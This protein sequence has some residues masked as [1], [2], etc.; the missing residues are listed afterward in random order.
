MHRSLKSIFA[1]LLPLMVLFILIAKTV[2]E[3]NQLHLIGDGEENFKLSYHLAKHGVISTGALD[4]AGNLLPSNAREPLPVVLGALWINMWPVLANADS[5][6]ELLLGKKIVLLKLQNVVYVAALLIGIFCLFFRLLPGNLSRLKKT[7]LATMVVTLC[8]ACMHTVFTN[9][10][11][12]EFH[13]ELLIIWFVWAWLSA[14]ESKG[15][16]C[17]FLAGLLLGLLVLTKAAFMYI[18]FASILFFLLFLVFSKYPIQIIFKQSIILIIA[19]LCVAPWFVRNYIQLGL[20]EHT[21]RGPVVLLVRAYKNAMTPEEFTGAFYA[22]APASLK[23]VMKSLT[24]FSATDRLT[25]G[26]L[27][28]LTRFPNGDLEKRAAGDEAGAISYYIKATTHDRNVH[29]DFQEKV[30]DQVQA[31]ILADQAIKKEA[32]KKITSDIPAHL[33][34]SLVFAW[35]GSWPCNTVDGRWKSSYPRHPVWQEFLPFL[36]LVSMWGILIFGV[37][38]RQVTSVI[39]SILGVSAFTFYAMA[40]HFL[41]RYSEMMISLWVICF[42]YLVT[43]SVF[44]QP[45]TV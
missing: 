1:F 2:L 3:V 15:Y 17:Y 21:Q 11:I 8:Y 20:W 19:T 25:G 16:I 14:W 26:R 27:Q 36:G 10:L 39:L 45:N 23:N 7:A 43:Q 4:Q 30:L 34:A 35:R 38:K 9:N 28:R 41:P 12:T 33:R 18:G 31:R 24:G 40:T 42:F 6:K 22:Y 29:L 5:S 32:I 13:G 44:R 37:L